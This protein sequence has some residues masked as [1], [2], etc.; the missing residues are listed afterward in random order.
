MLDCLDKIR[1]KLPRDMYTLDTV[2]DPSLRALWK[3]S[4]DVGT[5]V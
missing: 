2:T 1:N 3:S 4:L 5:E